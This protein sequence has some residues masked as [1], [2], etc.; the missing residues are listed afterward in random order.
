[1]GEWLFDEWL[2]W[3]EGATGFVSLSKKKYSFVNGSSFSAD[4]GPGQISE[5]DS[6]LHSRFHN[7][8]LSLWWV[9][10]DR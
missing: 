3:Q 10:Y 7:K 9:A 1:M 4:V 5:F 2:L 8:N 6:A